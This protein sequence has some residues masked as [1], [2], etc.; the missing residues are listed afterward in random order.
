V[1]SQTGG[2]PP[3]ASTFTPLPG[4]HPLFGQ[5]NGTEPYVESQAMT[6]DDIND[7]IKQF[8]QAA[9][10]A[11]HAGFDGVEIH[12]LSSPSSNSLLESN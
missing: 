8:A 10:N 9:R 12:G 4:N 7:V 6:I 11:V 2:Y 3:L 1:P 5:E